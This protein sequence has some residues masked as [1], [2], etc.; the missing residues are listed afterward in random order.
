MRQRVLAKHVVALILVLLCLLVGCSKSDTDIISASS[1][2]GPA[3]H[4][5]AN[6]A[7][8]VQS[9]GES[10]N[11]RKLEIST[12]KKLVEELE[13]LNKRSFGMALSVHKD[14]A[15]RAR[16]SQAASRLQDRLLEIAKELERIDPVEH[17]QWFFQISESMLDFDFVI[18]DKGITS[19]RLGDIIRWGK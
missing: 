17:K 6:K 19:L 11:V 9:L 2:N 16:L 4:E 13:T 3:R 12:P 14:P 15:L 10:I 8:Q 18:A 7:R 5:A 1:E